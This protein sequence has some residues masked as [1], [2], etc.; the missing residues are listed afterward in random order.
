MEEIIKARAND[1]KTLNTK[2]ITD[3]KLPTLYDLTMPSERVDGNIFTQLV[4]A[5][6]IQIVKNKQHLNK[7]N[8]FPIPDGDTG[9]FLKF[10]SPKPK[11]DNLSNTSL[12]Y[13][14]NNMVI[15]LKSPVKNLFTDPQ[16]SIVQAARNLACDVLLYGQGNSG[17]ILSH[18]FIKLSEE[19]N[20]IVTEDLAE[21]LA[22]K[23]AQEHKSSIKAF[24]D[25][26]DD[27]SGFI[28]V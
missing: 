11:K 3:E 1:L 7:T 15:C 27:R 21:V 17:T 22:E 8:V 5:G 26:D 24:L 14:G 9:K 4:L 18:F 12:M 28:E 25:V 13:T 6:Y 2:Q 10:Y 16:V 23:L 20:K 19:I